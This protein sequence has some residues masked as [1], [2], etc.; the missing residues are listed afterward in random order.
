MAYAMSLGRRRMARSIKI[1]LAIA[2][3]PCG[4]SAARAR[5][6]ASAG[7]ARHPGARE[8]R[9]RIRARRQPRAARA[10][11][12]AFSPVNLPASSAGI[13]LGDPSGRFAAP[14]YFRQA[15]APLDFGYYAAREGRAGA[16]GMQFGDL[17]V[18]PQLLLDESYN[19]N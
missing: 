9:S 5:R 15:P 18:L 6:A 1:T 11:S 12:A 19:S 13:A 10:Q 3:G 14:G 2:S 8:G 16:S 4:S 17:Q 7:I